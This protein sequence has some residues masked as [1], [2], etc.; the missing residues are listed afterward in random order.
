MLHIVNRRTHATTP[1]D[2]YVGRSGLNPSPLG[3]PYSIVGTRSTQRVDTIE[4][5]LI[6]YE[7]WLTAKILSGD[8][9][10]LAALEDIAERAEKGDVY[11][12]CHCINER[13]KKLCHAF[14]IKSVV[15]A[16]LEKRRNA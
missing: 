4:E 15:E 6:S 2:V 5:A 9:Q 1:N 11:L 7:Y 3:N 8:D 16:M 13:N 12:V 14:S 10:V